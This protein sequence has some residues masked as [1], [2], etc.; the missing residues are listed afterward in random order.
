MSVMARSRCVFAL[1]SLSAGLVACGEDRASSAIAIDGTTSGASGNANAGTASSAGGGAASGSP[2]SNGGGGGGASGGQPAG[3]QAG[4]GG[5]GK[6]G[7][8]TPPSPAPAMIWVNATGNL[9]NLASE[10]GNLGLVSAQPCSNRVIAGVAL[11]G[12]WETV[13]GGKTWTE[14]GQGAGSATIT[15]RISAIVYDPQDPKTFWESGIY[16]GPG[17]YKTTDSGT[18]FEALGDVVHCDSVS[19]D[20]SDPERK[21]L[22]AGGH[23]TSANLYKSVDGGEN[24]TNIAAGLPGGGYCTATQVIDAMNFLVACT[25]GT[26]Q[27]TAT[28]GS[29]W[30]PALGSTGGVFQPLLASDGTLYWPGANGGVSK[31]TDQGQSFT[32]V[33]TPAVAPG[34]VAPA[35]FAEL[36]DGRIAIIGTD[37]ILL[38]DDRGGSWT[39]IG[40]AMPYPGGGYDGARGLAYSA[41]TKTFFIWRWD[42]TAAVPA[43]AI[44]SMGFDW[45]AQ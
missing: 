9:A 32:T 42:C 31:S 14:L 39:P 20:L 16:N 34:L 21:T 1:A 13:D 8:D 38:S 35:Q 40:E 41:Q 12:L 29:A 25:N 27:R 22:I 37:H 30:A 36:P 23:E 6:V 19:V 10:C 5:A 24:W 43:D 2:A 28:A 15:N 18:T 3:G 26:I 45:E 11:K 33:A 4:S 7:C 44:M 17:V